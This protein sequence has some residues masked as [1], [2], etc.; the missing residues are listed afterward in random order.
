MVRVALPSLR[1]AKFLK[2]KML[3]CGDQIKSQVGN[4]MST[5]EKEKIQEG[6]PYGKVGMPN[7]CA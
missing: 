2:T 4:I 7:Y 5:G 6:V 1:L 3:V